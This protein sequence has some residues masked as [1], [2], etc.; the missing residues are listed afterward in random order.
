MNAF[1]RTLGRFCLVKIRD[2]LGAD[3]RAL[4]LFRIALGLLILAQLLDRALV[5][6]PFYTDRGLFP[7]S[8]AISLRKPWE[9]SF[10]FMTGSTGLVILL[11][12]LAAL[13]AIFLLIGY[14]T[15]L[16]AF[17]SYLF[18]VSL[19][20]RNVFIPNG[21]DYLLRILTFWSFFLPLG[22]RLSVDAKLNPS[23]RALPDR[24]L[25]AASAA[26]LFQAAF[27]YFFSALSKLSSGPWQ[28]GTAV[29]DA[30]ALENYARPFAAVIRSHLPA[31][32][33]KTAAY[34]VIGTELLGSI[35]LFSPFL[36]APLRMAVVAIFFL[37]QLGFALSLEVNLFPWVAVAA[38]LPFLPNSLC[39]GLWKRGRGKAGAEKGAFLKAPLWQNLITGFLLIYITL[40]NVEGLTYKSSFYRSVFPQFLIPSGIRKIGNLLALDQSWDMFIP[41]GR[42]TYWFVG[43]GKQKDGTQVD[44]FQ[45]GAPVNWEKPKR[46]F[47][48]EPWRAYLMNLGGRHKEALAPY[49]GPY[50]CQEWNQS[51]SGDK[52]L[53]EIEVFLMSQENTP[54]SERSKETQKYYSSL[55]QYSCNP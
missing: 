21:G 5:L 26:F 3:L 25:S 41:P 32:L 42:V 35:L 33:F 18:V 9:W 7:R 10:Y 1:A 30:C 16:A 46:F 15:R 17:F 45:D 24:T 44:I 6:E 31:G 12:F 8:L 50:F 39:D 48:N 23:F 19:Q 2:L 11:F 4:A 55:L 43:V 49:V 53:N 13:F 38:T 14:H 36:T 51:R 28:S 22:C 54:L 27:I 40:S 29:Y 37:M 47:K 34:G 52:K 20:S